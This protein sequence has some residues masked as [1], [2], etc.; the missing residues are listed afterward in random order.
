MP[1]YFAISGEDDA[2]LDVAK[3]LE[4][5]DEER[6]LLYVAMTRARRTLFLT[7]ARRRLTWGM[8]RDMVPSRFLSEIPNT[9]LNT[10]DLCEPEFRFRRNKGRRPD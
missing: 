4:A 2:D 3:M 8:A 7:T 10:I 9:L 5:V 1:H 6:R